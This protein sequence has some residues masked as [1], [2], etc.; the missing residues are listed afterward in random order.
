MR[1]FEVRELR[2]GKLA[3]LA[4]IG[5]RAFVKN[6][7]GVRRFAPFFMWEPDDRNLLHRRVSQKHAFD[8]DRRNIFAATDDDVFQAVANFDVTIRMHDRGVAGM[9][10]SAAQSPLGRFRVVVIAGHDHVAARD[11]FTLSNAIV[12]HVVALRVHH[13]QLARCNQL[14]PLAGFDRGSEVT[15]GNQRRDGKRSTGGG[16]SCWKNSKAFSGFAASGH[17]EGEEVLQPD[18][19]IKDVGGPWPTHIAGGNNVLIYP[20]PNHVPATFTVLNFP[21]DDVDRAVDELTKRGVQIR[22]L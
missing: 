6:N 16:L 12:R 7:K 10:P 22:S 2:P 19:G 4:L 17:R 14:N 8:F 11:D 15:F 20:K 1:R 18:T 21:V 9:K 5:A 3:Q 13:A